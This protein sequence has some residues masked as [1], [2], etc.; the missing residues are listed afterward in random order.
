M[1]V[2]KYVIKIHNFAGNKRMWWRGGRPPSPHQT[3]L[4]GK[5]TKAN[6]VSFESEFVGDSRNSLNNCEFTEF[7]DFASWSQKSRF[8][9]IGENF[10]VFLSIKYY[11]IRINQIIN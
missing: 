5:Q 7:R 10:K 6:Y 2:G 1:S 11:E 4:S 3:F 8:G 9:E